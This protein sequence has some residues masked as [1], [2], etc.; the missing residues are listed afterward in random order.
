MLIFKSA[1]VIK[2]YVTFAFLFVQTVK[3]YK[4][5]KFDENKPCGSRVMSIFTNRARL[6]KMMLGE[7]SSPFCIPA[8]GQC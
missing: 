8:A 6:A 7:A 1:R 3:L 4:Q 2:Y 5:A